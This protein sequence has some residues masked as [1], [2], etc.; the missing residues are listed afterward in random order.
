MNSP[1]ATV[2]RVHADSALLARSTLT[3]IDHV[4]AHVLR[5]DGDLS[6]TPEQWA[7]E[8]L[9]HP[10]AA[11]RLRLRAGWTALGIALHHG[12]PD[13]IAGWPITG[14]TAE[15]LRLQSDSRIG[16]HGQLITRLSDQGVTFA[17]LVELGN[18]VARMVWAKVLPGHLRTV[19]SL[20]EGAAQRTT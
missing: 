1:T 19:R 12:R 4:D 6:R 2:D 15:F 8:I 7:R 10:P 9:E 11:V 16:L 20:M 14:N 13:T 18:P 5:T 17:T 3:R